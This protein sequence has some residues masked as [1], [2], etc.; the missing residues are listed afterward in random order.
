MSRSH[1]AV[2]VEFTCFIHATEDEERVLR[3]LTNL[4]PEELRRP[5]SLP[6]RKSLTYGFYGN[7]IL[8]LHLEFSGEEADRIVRHIF[9]SMLGEDLRGILEG[10]E[11]RFAKGR[12]YLRFDKQ[13]AYYGIMKLS[14]GDEV[15]RCV[16]K[17]KPHI[18]RREDLERVLKEYGAHL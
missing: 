11:N 12:L 14:S 7:P 1:V 10:F 8:L 17:L 9:S 18:R 15:I 6:L 5:D 16:I 3:A 2:S 4:L 13:E